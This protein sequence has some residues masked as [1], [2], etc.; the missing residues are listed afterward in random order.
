MHQFS[1]EAPV[2]SRLPVSFR[3]YT[4]VVLHLILQGMVY[5]EYTWEIFGLCQ[6][7]EFSLYY[8]FLPYLLLIVNLLFFT[9]SCV[10]NPGKLRLLV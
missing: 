6:Q 7:L 3:N 2:T 9:L 8:L 10:T 4:F 5:T 1:W